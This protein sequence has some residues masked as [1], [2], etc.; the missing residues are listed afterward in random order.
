MVAKSYQNCEIL[1][2]PFIVGNKKYV[3][4]KLKSGVT[5]QVRYYT[6]AQYAKLYREAPTDHSND[7][8]WKSQKEVL[9]FKHGYI[10]IFAGAT[11][12]VKDELKALGAVYRQNWGWGISSEATAP[13]EDQIPEGVQMLKLEWK[14]VGGDNEKLFCDE[15]VQKAVDK[16]IAEH[17]VPDV[18]IGSH[19]GTVG[20]RLELYVKVVRNIETRFGSRMMFM[21]DEN[22]NTY[23]WATSAKSWEPGEE[24]K[25]RGTVKKHDTYAGVAQTWLTRC[26]EVK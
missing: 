6:D 23:V 15:E 26:T 4:I 11:Y 12:P 20:E 17:K 10:W 3:N 13:S 5:K 8:Y 18:E 9:G 24:K 16:L 22:D 2:E 14:D 1:C 19:V 7:P 25:I 21:V